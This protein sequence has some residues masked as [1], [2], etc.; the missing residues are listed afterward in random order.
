MGLEAK[1]CEDTVAPEPYRF[2]Y[3]EYCVSLSI[4]VDAAGPKTSLIVALSAWGVRTTKSR[5]GR[6]IFF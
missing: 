2:G 1:G 3:C 5:R 4:L 6:E